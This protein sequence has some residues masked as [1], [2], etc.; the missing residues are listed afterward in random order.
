MDL[1]VKR[2]RSDE[3]C[4]GGELLVDNQHAGWTLEPP[5]RPG[6]VKPRAI[7]AGTYPLTIAWSD[8]HGRD[9]PRV[10]NVPG[11]DAIEIHIGNFP[12]DTLGCLLVGQT[13]GKDG[14]LNSAAEFLKLYVE[15]KEAFAMGR[16]G[17]ITYVDLAQEP[18]IAA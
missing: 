8:K 17:T 4:V 16:L 5:Y 12:K 11:F 13:R 1:F 9:L 3:R 10:L 14:V 15:M 2:D 6:N 7:P 18:P